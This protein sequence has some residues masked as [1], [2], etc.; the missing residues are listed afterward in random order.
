MFESL[1]PDFHA[2]GFHAQKLL[3]RHWWMAGWPS[4]PQ[5]PGSRP[6]LLSG[7]G[8]KLPDPQNPLPTKIPD[9][10][11]VTPACLAGWAAAG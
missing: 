7:R 3:I 5:S 10:P 11:G 6:G 9:E 1:R 8:Q 4:C 2:H